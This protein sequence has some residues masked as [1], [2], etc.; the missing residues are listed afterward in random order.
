M[1]IYVSIMFIARHE[2]GIADQLRVIA[3]QSAKARG[4]PATKADTPLHAP[5]ISPKCLLEMVGIIEMP[6]MC[7]PSAPLALHIWIAAEWDWGTKQLG[8]GGRGRTE[9]LDG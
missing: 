4:K 7:F 8:V 1:C 9:D 3:G 5:P 6:K 2:G